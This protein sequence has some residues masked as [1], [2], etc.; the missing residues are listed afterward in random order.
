MHNIFI[1]SCNETRLEIMNKYYNI[2]NIETSQ[3]INVI[4]DDTK[5]KSIDRDKLKMVNGDVYLASDIISFCREKLG[6][7]TKYYDWYVDKYKPTIKMLIFYYVKHKLGISKSFLMDD[8]ILFFKPIDEIF[9]N[10]FARKKDML[11]SIRKEENLKIWRTLFSSSLVDKTESE[12]NYI[13]S[14][15]I[16]FDYDKQD[17]ILE[18]SLLN[19]FNCD[20]L[21]DKMKINNEKNEGH[22]RGFSGTFWV[23][24]QYFFAFLLHQIHEKVPVIELTGSQ[25][26]LHTMYKHPGPLKKKPNIIHILPIRKEEIYNMYFGVLDV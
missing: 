11:S 2:E 13:N 23:T 4:L 14:G 1:L 16:L 22:R 25:V 18:K 12:K 9:E 24:E 21:Y 7:N 20:E 19:F 15:T 6:K 5:L 8:D 3:K 10:S 17:D 26:R